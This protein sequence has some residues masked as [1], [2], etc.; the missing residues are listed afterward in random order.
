[1]PVFLCLAIYPGL[2]LSLHPCL[3]P[4]KNTE[5]WDT[6]IKRADIKRRPLADIVLTVTAATFR[7]TGEPET[8]VRP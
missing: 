2:P 8:E 1:M 6:R 4:E 7:L 3:Y 5:L